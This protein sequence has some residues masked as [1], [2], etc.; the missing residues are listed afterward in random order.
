GP[1]ELPAEKFPMRIARTS[2][3]PPY[4]TNSSRARQ[5]RPSS[6]NNAVG[7]NVAK[8]LAR[9]STSSSTHL[10]TSFGEINDNPPRVPREPSV[11]PRSH[12]DRRNACASS[13][14][15]RYFVISFHTSRGNS[16]ASSPSTE[17][18]CER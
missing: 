16:L 3:R 4:R 7:T 6:R 18:V 8:Y 14:G 11:S 12:R 10:Q 9:F 5:T 1:L 17:W 15:P 13:G 2:W